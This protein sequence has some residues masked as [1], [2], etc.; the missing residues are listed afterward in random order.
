MS[1]IFRRVRSVFKPS[2]RSRRTTSEPTL[3]PYDR[4]NTVRN[5]PRKTEVV[6]DD[7]DDIDSDEENIREKY[8][9]ASTET[10]QQPTNTR[11]TLS[12]PEPTPVITN[13]SN[14]NTNPIPLPIQ[15]PS[16]SAVRSERNANRPSQLLAPRVLQTPTR[17][18]LAPL[19]DRPRRPLRISPKSTLI[20]L[21]SNLIQRTNRFQSPGQFM[22]YE[23]DYPIENVVIDGNI[24]SSI[25]M[26]VN[27][28]VEQD[29]FGHHP[30]R[31][32]RSHSN[33]VRYIREIPLHNINY[34]PQQI[35]HQTVQTDYSNRYDPNCY[36]RPFHHYVA[37]AL[38]N[39]PMR[40]Y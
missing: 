37:C 20:G 2:A 17:R 38:P 36:P 24:P 7:T 30:Q 8:M 6:N 22:S 27:R 35:I 25:A 10:R 11:P 23:Y 9:S 12:V 29:R 15:Q 14:I 32:E 16:A 26:K 34:S 19:F 39:D 1:K 31:I 4:Q 40:Y 5:K 21:P 13:P 33:G 28:A 3:T 18:S